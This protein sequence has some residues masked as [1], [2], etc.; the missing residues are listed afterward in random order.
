MIL[1][2]FTG[3]VIEMTP[4]IQSGF[5]RGRNSR[6]HNVPSNSRVRRRRVFGRNFK[7]RLRENYGAIQCKQSL[8]TSYL[9][10][11]GLSDA[12][13]E[14]VHSFAAINSPDLLFLVETKR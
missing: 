12:K 7:Y 11:D 6:S 14:D 13:L 8:S 1:L 10:V 5:R 3:F 9:N 4:P 2:I